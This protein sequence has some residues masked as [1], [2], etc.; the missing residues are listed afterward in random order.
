MLPLLQ[1]AGMLLRRH[2]RNEH[3]KSVSHSAGH[4][5]ALRPP[6]Q[7]TKYERKDAD[8]DPLV[9]AA[10]YN[11]RR[12]ALYQLPEELLL[13]IMSHLDPIGIFCLRRTGRLFLRLFSSYNFDY[14]HDHESFFEPGPHAAQKLPTGE[15]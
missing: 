4:I 6:G 1:K 10:Q 8:M 12:S 15:D 3:E 5:T 11:I 2:F 14:L 13:N 7:D 9:T